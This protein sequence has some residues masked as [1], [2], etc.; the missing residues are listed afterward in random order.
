MS[1]TKLSLVGN[2]LRPGRVWLVTGKWPSFFT[3]YVHLRHTFPTFIVLHYVHLRRTFPTFIVLHYIC[4]P[5]SHIPYVY[6]SALY[7]HQ[8]NTFP[9]LIVL[10]YV[11]LRHTFPRLIVLHYVHLRHTFP[12]LIVLHYVHLYATHSLRLLFCTMCTYATHSLGLLFCTMCTTT[13]FSNLFVYFAAQ[14]QYEIHW[15][16]TTVDNNSALCAL[17]LTLLPVL[18]CAMGNMKHIVNTKFFSFSAIFAPFSAICSILY[19]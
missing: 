1:L 11:H 13:Y 5:T 12:R 17:R 10:H 9:R 3:V 15:Q 4:T 2:D 6:C 16:Y 18:F 14:W 7:V 8:R 19:T